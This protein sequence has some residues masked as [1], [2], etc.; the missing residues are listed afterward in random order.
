MYNN[1]VFDF[2]IN[3]M[4]QPLE[5]INE[6]IRLLNALNGLRGDEYEFTLRRSYSEVLKAY[7]ASPNNLNVIGVY[8][9]LL[10]LKGNIKESIELFENKLIPNIKDNDLFLKALALRNFAEI[11]L[12]DKDYS[13][14]IDIIE[15]A[16]LLVTLDL[17][18]KLNIHSFS[19]IRTALEIYFE[20]GKFSKIYN[21]VEKNNSDIIIL[22]YKSFYYY[23]KDDYK[24]TFNTLKFISKNCFKHELNKENLNSFFD[25][26][27]LN[28]IKSAFKT[29][30]TERE[31]SFLDDIRQLGEMFCTYS[32]KEIYFKEK[33]SFHNKEY[34]L[35]VERTQEGGF[36][37]EISEIDGCYTQGNTLEELKENILDILQMYSEDELSI[38]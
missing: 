35:N 21:I 30:L 26:L 36:Y 6:A 8:A 11:L 23:Y 38:A 20:S 34:L 22:I 25:F 31:Q 4:N 15:K 3:E 5:N 17:T 12:I 29:K 2:F 7:K 37:G 14:S 28:L 18:E 10:G 33:I 19:P 9:T 24:K 27:E 1:Y 16:L 32:L 13:K